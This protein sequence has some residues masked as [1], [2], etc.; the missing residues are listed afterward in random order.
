MGVEREKPRL[1]PDI[2]GVRRNV[3]RQVAEDFNA[4]FRRISAQRGPLAVEKQLHRRLQRGLPREQGAVT[5]ER[6]RLPQADVL[7]PRGPSRAAEMGLQRGKKRPV[8]H[9]RLRRGEV[10]RRTRLPREQ[11]LRRA[12]EQG[13]A[14]AVKRAVVHAR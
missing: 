9:P 13:R 6:L 8:A 14:R 7:L 2:G 12:A 3:K 1:R 4:L 11:A 10:L 5:R